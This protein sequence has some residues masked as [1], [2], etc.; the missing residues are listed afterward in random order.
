MVA[1]FL[2]VGFANENYD[3]E[4]LNSAD[5]VV[6]RLRSD[7]K[8][9]WCDLPEA[10]QEILRHND[11]DQFYYQV[12]RQ[13]GTRISG[14]SV[15]PGPFPNL[16]SLEPVFRYTT[17]NGKDIRVCRIRVDL[18]D[19]PETILVQFAETLNSRHQLAQQILMSIVIPQI[20]LILLGAFAVSRGVTVG[21]KPLV[22]LEQALAARSQADLS[23]LLEVDTPAEVHP[24]VRSINDLLERLRNDIETQKRF[25]A[26]AAHQ[27]RTPLAGLKTYIYYAKKLASEETAVEPDTV[28]EQM[29]TILNQIDNGTDRMSHLANRLLALLKAEPAIVSARFE[30]VDLNLIAS[31]VTAELVGEAVRKNID[32]DFTGCDRPALIEG[33]TSGLTELVENLIENAILY[34]QASGRISVSVFANSEK[35]SLGVEDDGPGIPVEERQKVFERFYR[36]L[37]SDAPGSGLGLSI[38]KEIATSHHAEISIHSGPDGKGTVVKVEFP[39]LAAKPVAAL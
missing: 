38:V 28:K 36:I 15:L 19:F 5:S 16:E 21:L 1:Y 10:A 4:L 9:V 22:R 7:G 2:A 18:P 23:P 6:A 3:R 29:T 33:D 34:T 12:I 32:L 14:D 25:V 27:F 37:G 35:V 17:L 20:V 13:D 24:L 8:T 39:V 30:K 31:E 11:R 26:N